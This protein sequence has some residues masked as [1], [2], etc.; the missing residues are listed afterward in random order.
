[1]PEEETIETTDVKFVG[2]FSLK[3]FYDLLFDLFV[4]M[5]YDVIEK[6]YAYKEVGELEME[7][8]CEKK[9]DDFT[10]FKIEVKVYLADYKSGQEVKKGERWDKGDIRTRLKAILR[11]DYEAKWETHAMLKFLKGIYEKYLYKSTYDSFKEKIKS[12]M[13]SIS[14]EVKAFFGMQKTVF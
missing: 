3:E 4:S 2:Y 8:S 13:Y 6:K 7:W 5:G 1:M 12:E 10:M 11:T 14:S 9:V